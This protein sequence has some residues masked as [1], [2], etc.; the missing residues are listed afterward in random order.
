MIIYLGADH[1]GFALKEEIEKFLRGEGYEVGD[2]GD[3]VYN[4][5]DDFPYF[6]APVAKKVSEDPINS[7]GI[8]V[9]GSGVGVMIVANKFK[10]VRAATGM[11]PDHVHAARHDEDI[12]VLAL[13][14]DFTDQE[15]AK[16]MVTVFLTTPFGGDERYRRR[17]DEIN[18]LEHNA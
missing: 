4:A 7:R 12:N 18:S 9:C 14:A 10:G 16:K 2:L 11:S 5:E 15:T 1:R 17:L 8:V 3:E 13:A 6:S